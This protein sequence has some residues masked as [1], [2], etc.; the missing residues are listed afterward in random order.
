MRAGPRRSIVAG[1]STVSAPDICAAAVAGSS[2]QAA[3]DPDICLMNVRRFT[4]SAGITWTPGMW[5]R[6][7]GRPRCDVVSTRRPAISCA[8]ALISRSV[9]VPVLFRPDAH[10]RSRGLLPRGNGQHEP[11]DEHHQHEHEQRALS[12]TPA[13]D[14]P[15]TAV[16]VLPAAAAR[17]AI[18]AADL[19]LHVVYSLPD[20][21]RP[22]S[23]PARTSSCLRILPRSDVLHQSRPPHL[24]SRAS[25]APPGD[26]RP[27][28]PTD[29]PSAPTWGRRVPWM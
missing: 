6:P 21:P 23:R 28:H 4:G 24:D 22:A 14:L 15:F 17:A 9:V 26:A 27:P 5:R 8:G 3:A 19:R 20:T 18:V 11:A 2:D 25:H 16:L 1:R 13:G 12:G 10:L 7:I 29:A